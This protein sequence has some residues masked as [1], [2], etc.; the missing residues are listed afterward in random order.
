IESGQPFEIEI[1]KAGT[2]VLALAQ[3][4]QPAQASLKPFQTQFFEQAPVVG[5]SSAPLVIVIV[6][7]ERVGGAP[8]ATGYPKVVDVYA[9]H[10]LP[11]ADAIW[12]KICHFPY[13]GV[14]PGELRA[15]ACGRDGQCTRFTASAFCPSG[16]STACNLASM[17]AG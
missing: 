17:P 6:P 14:R 11:H 1:V 12:A 13:A 7:V 3:D 5:D 10:V 8:P 2:K 9:G 15:D 16:E 4:G